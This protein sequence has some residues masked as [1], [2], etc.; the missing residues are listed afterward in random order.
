MKQS[1]GILAYRIRKQETEFFLVHPGGPFWK[2]KDLGAWSIPKGE[3]TDEEDAETAA[4]REFQ[5]ETG[6]RVSGKTDKL[7]VVKLKSGKWIH[8]FAVRADFDESLLKSNEFDLEWP[9]RSGKKIRVPEVDRGG[10]FRLEEARQKINAGQLPILEEWS[11]A[12]RK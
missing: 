2:N 12:L 6:F 4:R 5:E 9:P 10:W 8:A 11:A 1:A 7:R 3:F